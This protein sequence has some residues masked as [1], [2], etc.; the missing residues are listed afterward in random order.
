MNFWEFLKWA[1]E[2]L[3]WVEGALFTVWLY[4]MYWGKK[5][6]MKNL[7]VEEQRRTSNERSSICRRGDSCYQ[8]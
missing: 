1:W 3:G 6:L 5:H 8:I 4:G 2:T 7:D